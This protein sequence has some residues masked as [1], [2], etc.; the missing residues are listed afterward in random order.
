MATS[1][2]EVPCLQF[3]PQ[4]W[5]KTVCKTC[6]HSLAKHSAAQESATG[7][8]SNEDEALAA[9]LSSQQVDHTAIHDAVRRGFPRVVR[10]LVNLGVTPH[11]QTLRGAVNAA[12]PTDDCS[13]IEPLF[14]TIRLR[15]MD[16]S[17]ELE[18]AVKANATRVASVLLRTNTNASRCAAQV[19]RLAECNN[20]EL[21][22]QLLRRPEV[23]LP[24]LEA[25]VCMALMRT[26][27]NRDDIETIQMLLSHSPAVAQHL[28]DLLRNCIIHNEREAVRHLVPL[29][30]LAGYRVDS[31]TQLPQDSHSPLLVAIRYNRADIVRML[32]RDFHALLVDYAGHSVLLHAIQANQPDMLPVLVR[33]MGLDPNGAPPPPLPFTS[34]RSIQLAIT[35][36]FSTGA[37]SVALVTKLLELGADPRLVSDP[38]TTNVAAALRFERYADLLRLLRK[39]GVP[40]EDFH[41]AI[42]HVVDVFDSQHLQ[43]LLAIAPGA[44]LDSMLTPDGYSL[45]RRAAERSAPITRLLLDAGAHIIEPEYLPNGEQRVPIIH[46]AAR[47]SYPLELLNLLLDH[48]ADIETRFQGRT[49]IMTAIEAATDDV[50]RLFIDR[51]ADIT[52]TASASHLTLMHLACMRSNRAIIQLLLE[53]G[54]AITSVNG[55]YPTALLPRNS[56]LFVLFECVPVYG[57]CPVCGEETLLELSR[58]CGHCY[59]KS[60]VSN[61]V[62]V[63]IEQA[64]PHIRCLMSNCDAL[65]A[66]DT[67]LRLVTDEQR[68]L[69]DRILAE[70]ACAEMGDFKWCPRCS[71]GGFMAFCIDLE[72]N[73]CSY[74]WCGLCGEQHQA[75]TACDAATIYAESRRLVSSVAKPCPGCQILIQHDG[76]CAHVTCCK[77]RYE[78]CWVCRGPYRRY[79]NWDLT[80]CSCASYD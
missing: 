80:S 72:C 26:L 48:G 78:W 49:P 19:L 47:A 18:C 76:G 53:R 3:V 52:A 62:S 51:G 66:G 25:S 45:V 65:F 11:L 60:C 15:P 46:K 67:I 9:V 50:V 40:T 69:V 57:E 5:R 35:Y 10:A 13:V 43:E 36:G 70:S 14:E 71:H 17:S 44:P 58:T 38:R 16:L 7:S 42:P 75:G 79:T 63:A 77:C 27:A 54:A 1:E 56:S 4:L 28:L 6:F 55:V 23:L 61:W 2:F 33:E 12:I 34:A 37:A 24:T 31:R 8:A 68:P 22:R 73:E 21:V 30:P 32:V 39:G 20:I 41:A 64:Q 59:C 74:S 29:L